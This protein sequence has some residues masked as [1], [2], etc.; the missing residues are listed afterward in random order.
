MANYPP[1][2]V[3]LNPDENRAYVVKFESDVV[4]MKNYYL[5]SGKEYIAF[6]DPLCANMWQCV[7]DQGDIVSVTGPRTESAH[8]PS[9]TYWQFLRL[10]EPDRT[11]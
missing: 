7:D 10:A 8:L 4:W 6:P 9:D 2:G 3:I 1:P 11:S 5:T